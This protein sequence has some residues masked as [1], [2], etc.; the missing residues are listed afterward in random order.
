MTMQ[1]WMVRIIKVRR[2][3]AGENAILNLNIKLILGLKVSLFV[4]F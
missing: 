3:N 2:S 4:H 1:T